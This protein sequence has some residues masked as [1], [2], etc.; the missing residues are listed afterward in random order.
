MPRLV[1]FSLLAA[2]VPA[3]APAQ[4]GGAANPPIAFI[5]VNVVPMD[6]ERVLENQTVLIREGRIAALG[7]AASTPAPPNAQRIAGAGR[8]LIPG[9]AEMHAHIPP[10]DSD[11]RTSY[12]E[13]VLFLYVAHGVTTIRGMLGHPAH[14]DLRRR[15]ESGSVLGPRIWTSGPSANGNTA[16]TAARGDSIAR[17]NKAI[18][19]DFIKIH[20]GV[21]R[22]AFDALDAAAD[23]V[24][25]PFAGHVPQDVGL[26]RALEARYASID[27][28]DGYMDVLLRDGAPVDRSAGGWFGANWAMSADEG[29]IPAIARATREAGVWNVPT[30]TLMES[31]ASDETAASMAAR[32]DLRY[33][34]PRTR[35][36]WRNWKEQAIRQGP[37]PATMR[38]FIEV[39][40]TLIKALHDAG[41]GLLLGSDAPQVWNV[42][43]AS[44]HQEL[45]AVVRAGL[46][47]YQ[48][49]ETGTLNVA[50][51][52]GVD[53]R[54]G[55][56]AAGKQ[57]DLVLLDGNPLADIRNTSR[58]AGVM[59]RGRWIP[60]EEIV[61]RLER[62]AAQYREP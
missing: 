23:Q 7:P 51:F 12:A 32:P 22:A 14:L 49:L 19:Y 15:V 6:G 59:I 18:G 1:Q 41:A 62:I 60:R 45:E 40:R 36:A 46:T 4:Q 52:F 11:G 8:Y 47:P 30:Q 35:A 43:G 3:L 57:A 16:T 61:A 27:H 33:M 38:R 17:A 34:P 5:G 50:R 55:T 37:P 58:Q 56:I 24:G 39:R 10:P 48:A 9:L 44:V 26:L 29:K 2:L 28:L 53:D 54:A 31:Y 20:P 25:I 42:P 13:E 21:T